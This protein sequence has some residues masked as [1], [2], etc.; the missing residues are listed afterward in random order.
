MSGCRERQGLWELSV[1]VMGKL[2]LAEGHC[3][4]ASI[5]VPRL[6]VAE[7]SGY[8]EKGSR[9]D[10]GH[11][12][13]V[14]N[15]HGRRIVA[16]SAEYHG[17]YPAFISEPV[18]AAD[19]KQVLGILWAFKLEENAACAHRVGLEWHTSVWR[20][21]YTNL[22]TKPIQIYCMHRVIVWATMFAKLC[23]KRSS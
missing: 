8:R 9:E 21:L 17:L 3:G 11:L 15:V 4:S 7:Q 6:W 12:W 5:T 18:R 23:S 13:Q 14:L 10:A 1:G 16:Q 20:I 22:Y 19:A 2:I